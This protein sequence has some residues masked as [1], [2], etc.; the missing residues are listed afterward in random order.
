MGLLIPNMP[1]SQSWL[2]G[3]E[4]GNSLMKS[5]SSNNDTLS[6]VFNP[7]PAGAHCVV[8]DMNN[9]YARIQSHSDGD[10]ST[11]STMTTYI[12]GAIEEMDG[13]LP[14]SRWY[15]R[16][17]IMCSQ[18]EFGSYEFIKI[19]DENGEQTQP[20]YSEYLNSMKDHYHTIWTGLGAEH[21]LA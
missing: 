2:G 13:V 4:L 21:I 14:G 6:F 17:S 7:C 3:T 19:I 1:F 16:A 15:R 18:V 5:Q 11:P 10:L 12:T 8:G 9:A 20:Y